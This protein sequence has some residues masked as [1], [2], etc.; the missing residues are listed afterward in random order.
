MAEQKDN[1]ER[2]SLLLRGDSADSNDDGHGADHGEEG[3]DTA[4]GDAPGEIVSG[5]P[6]ASDE[7][8][9]G[10]QP[11]EIP[12]EL[13][14]LPIRNAVVFP[15][16][17]VPL[18]ISR[19]K[20]K[21]V[22]DLALAG[23]RMVAIVAQRNPDVEDPKFE[24]LYR[25]GTAC[26]ILKMYKLADGSET[27]IVHGLRRVGIESVDL[28]EGYLKAVV[29]P[30]TE[31]EEVTTEHRALVEAIRHA[32]ERIIELSPNIPDEALEVLRGIDRPGGLADFLAA[33][34]AIGAL[35]KQEL[36][37]T[38]DV[39]ERLKKINLSVATQLQVAELSNK[40]QQQVQSQVDQ[41]QREYY[42][43]EQMKAIQKELGE[44]GEDDKLEVL[45]ERI[46]A[47][48][49]PEQVEAEANRE[50]E[51]MER[52]PPISPEYSL[53]L[54]YIEWLVDLPWKK[55]TEDNLDLARAEQIL[56]EDHYGLEKVK[57]RILEFL[58]VRLLKKDSRGPILCFVGPPGVGK[59][60]LGQ[61]IARAMGRQFIRM[62]LGGIHDEAAIR[63]HRR[64]YIGS[65][66]GRII[67]EIRRA[68]TNNPLFMLDEID[69]VGADYRGDPMSALLEVLDPAQN[70]TF[71]DHY[72]GVPFDLS[73]VLF[74]ATGNYVSAIERALLDR[75]EVI[76]IS[77]YTP[78]EKLMIAR[79]H[80]LPR[81]LSENGL[82]PEQLEL[83]DEV[84][85]TIIGD[86]TREAGVRTLERKIGSV[87]RA[88][89]TVIARG[90][91]YEKTMSVER[92]RE[93]L[94]PRDYE[95]EVAAT[96]SMPGVATGLAFT[97]SGGEILFIEAS[98]MPGRGNLSL[99]G[100]LGDV[101][102]ESA[103]AAA[104]IIRAHMAQLGLDPELFRSTDMHVHVPA[105]AIPKD[106]PSAGVA[107]LV[108]MVSALTE[109]T[110]DPT[111]GMTGE[112]T[113][114]GRVLPVGGIREK[115]LAA[116]RAGLK[117]VILPRRNEPHLEELPPETRAQ[118]NFIFVES[119]D[120]L[121]RYVF[122]A[123][124]GAR[125]ER[126]PR[127]R[128]SATSGGKR[129]NG[130]KSPK[131]SKRGKTKKSKTKKKTTR[132]PKKKRRRSAR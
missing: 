3:A 54:D 11:A 115:V 66:P 109:R 104:S 38:F 12:K 23:S 63:G 10:E 111:V 21:K 124:E 132:S 100:Q 101:M 53:A 98:K 114:S 89:A 56:D 85:N 26:T 70:S 15:G 20:S 125:S 88:H 127:K 93:I 76:E 36:L 119:I 113:L 106:G 42:L 116:H 103:H 65:M 13:P 59:T 77:G 112:I 52:I 107:I 118:L 24:D 27:I 97:P 83:T 108:A 60:S 62:S 7:S 75:M 58:A 17:I 91:S 44:K 94:G 92:A 51:R 105:G 22:L 84:I 129:K 130:K 81:Q 46:K 6:I 34:L 99:T 41:S 1:T 29:H 131:S 128:K 18:Q 86:Y 57:K 126:S 87:C 40:I 39:T 35:Y 14:I 96:T 80:L 67:R 82:T 43:R 16:T 32:A 55:G 78:Q 69:K 47:A 37:E 117:H 120:E 25:V 28:G 122:G 72:L 110:V 95:S 33:N 61:S 79:R 5:E 102:R 19:A 121:L 68:G 31:P 4:D 45:R 48:N 71:S 30:Y 8:S 9:F 49:M 74:I 2:D 90:E 123:T 64:T 50:L 73:K